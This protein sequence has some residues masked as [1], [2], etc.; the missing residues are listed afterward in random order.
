MQSIQSTLQTLTP[1][2]QHISTTPKLDAELLLSHIIEQPRS[3]LYA[4][5]EQLLSP[6]QQTQVS[7]LAARRAQGEP[8]AYILGKQA[9]WS[10]SL[11]VTKD[12]LIPRPDTEAL[13]AWTLDTFP[14]TPLS[15]ADLGTG[16]GAIALALAKERPAWQIT[17]TDCS[18]AALNIAQYNAAQ[19][20]LQTVDFY[21]GDWCA[22]LPKN[23]YNVILSNPPYIATNDPHLDALHHEP[24][25][26]L[27]AK[28]NG[29]AAIETIITQAMQKLSEGGAL[30]IEHGYQQAKAVAA[31]MQHAGYIRIENRQD[32]AKHPRFTVG[33]R[34]QP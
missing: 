21:L 16:S 1:T 18:S 25:H 9:F 8:M 31:L 4:H 34:P 20:Q 24:E 6:T 27:V 13:V 3:F 19:H 15:V 28:A 23:T 11:R 32:L 30:V 17:A 14:N 33:W 2:L 12:T 22:A 29:L 5:P 26:A 7:T 10:L